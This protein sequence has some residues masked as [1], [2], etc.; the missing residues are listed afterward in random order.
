MHIIS[1]KVKI[2]LLL[3]HCFP[4]LSSHQQTRTPNAR[5]GRRAV[6][7][8]TRRTQAEP[9][10]AATA[11]TIV[12]AWRLCPAT[13]LALLHR[14]P[15]DA[16]VA[17]GWPSQS[18]QFALQSSSISEWIRISLELLRNVLCTT[19]NANLSEHER[20]RQH[21][22]D[23]ARIRSH[24]GWDHAHAVF[25]DAVGTADD[26]RILGECALPAAA[27]SGSVPGRCYLLV[28]RGLQATKPNAKSPIATA[29]LFQSG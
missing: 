14:P 28:H 24:G 15:A 9:G 17:I 19:L 21:E 23:H 29:G 3:T 6:V 11:S 18:H 4:L 5:R 2:N 22:H 13:G 16:P 26:G 25:P 8:Q 12:A 10:S 27:Q 20:Q 1:Y 7:P